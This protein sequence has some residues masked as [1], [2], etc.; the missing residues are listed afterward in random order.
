MTPV[1]RLWASIVSILAAVALAVSIADA[2]SSGSRVALTTTA[3]PTFVTG[4]LHVKGRLYLQGKPVTA[5]LGAT[6]PTGPQGLQGVQG[7]GGPQGP[8]GPQGVIGPAGSQG[9]TGATGP[10]GA[11]G[12]TGAPGLTPP[13]PVTPPVVSNHR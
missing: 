6:G 3:K 13:G 2:P 11:T 5:T 4:D 7:A 12:A 9:A 10:T 8:A 1:G